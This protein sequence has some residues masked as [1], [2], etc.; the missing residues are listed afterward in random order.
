MLELVFGSLRFNGEI[1]D[2]AFVELGLLSLIYLL[3]CSS[4]QQ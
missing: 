2:E 1:G 4:F 3:E